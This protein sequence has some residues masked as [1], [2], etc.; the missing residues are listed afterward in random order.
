METKGVFQCV[1]N[2]LAV[3]ASRIKNHIV[4]ECEKVKDKIARVW[5]WQTILA[6]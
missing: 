5:I 3:L 2:E 1:Q 6:H 4:F